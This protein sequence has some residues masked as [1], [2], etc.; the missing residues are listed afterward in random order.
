M[1]VLRR[2]K[3]YIDVTCKLRD[4]VDS[5]K[6]VEKSWIQGSVVGWLLLSS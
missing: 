1:M 6:G 2:G 3:G 4:Q 5:R